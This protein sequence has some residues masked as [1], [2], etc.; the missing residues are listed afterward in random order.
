MAQPHST[1]SSACVLSDSFIAVKFLLHPMDLDWLG[2]LQSS[3]HGG[4]SEVLTSRSCPAPP[5]ART[6]VMLVLAK[7]APP[8]Q[9]EGRLLP[10]LVNS[11]AELAES[12]TVDIQR[13]SGI[14]SLQ[15]VFAEFL[16]KQQD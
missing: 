4:D 12:L 3:P 14:E 8:R 13:N 9:L 11:T 2:H 7:R 6:P 5:S 15:D 1:S 16:K 10:R